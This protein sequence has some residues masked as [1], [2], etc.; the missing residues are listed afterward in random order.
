MIMRR[1]ILNILLVNITSVVCISF[2]NSCTTD[3]IGGSINE[4]NKFD[5]TTYEWLLQEE[6]TNI[7][8][9]LFDKA[10]LV[11]AINGD[12]TIISPSKYSVNRYVRRRN[13]GVRNGVEGA[14][15]FALEDIEAEELKKMSMYIFPGKWGR[16]NIPEEGVY[17]TSIDGK[18]EIYLTLD[19]TNTDPTAAWDGGNAAGAGYQYSNFLLTTPKIIHVLFKRGDTWELNYLDRANLGFDADACDQSYRM[20]ISD[21]HTRNGV[22][23][24]LYSGDTSYQEHFYY[25]SLFFHGKHTED[26]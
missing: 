17:L 8:A 24:I 10:D 5:V 18:Q 11:D 6:T 23:H 20:M 25:H 2:L 26:I 13:Y 15:P 4:F 21:I 1:N 16:D 7:V 14:V 19:E 12:V 22:I 3:V 9:Q